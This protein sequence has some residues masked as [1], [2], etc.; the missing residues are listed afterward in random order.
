MRARSFLYALVA[1]TIIA[2]GF[3]GLT[4]AY[5]GQAV[6][7]PSGVQSISPAWSVPAAALLIHGWHGGYGWH[8]RWRR[9]WSGYNYPYSLPYYG[10][11]YYY[12]PN[13]AP[14]CPAPEQWDSDLRQWVCQL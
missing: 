11:G 9:G 2:V 4:V 6:A 3:A 5:A 13:V 10:G 12:G 8:H 14:F 7:G 1:T